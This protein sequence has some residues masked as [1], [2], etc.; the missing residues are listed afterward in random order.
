VDFDKEIVPWI[1]DEFFI[2][3]S[4]YK[5]IP[6][7]V[8]PA[9][10]IYF[11]LKAKDKDAC[12]K[13]MSKIMAALKQPFKET[14]TGDVTIFHSPV[15]TPGNIIPDFGITFAFVN[16]F[17]I[18]TTSKDAAASL[19]VVLQKKESSLALSKPFVESIGTLAK[20]SLFT[21]FY[22][23]VSGGELLS[24]LAKLSGEA[25]KLSEKELDI[26]KIANSFGG[27]FTYN[28]ACLFCRAVVDINKDVLL[29]SVIGMVKDASAT[30]KPAEEKAK[31][32][33]KK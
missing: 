18:M 15:P 24:G 25:N 2:S 28:D 9:P 14:K 27:G 30:G 23:G 22:N 4:N 5:I 29:K 3:V 7:P 1:G 11:G 32:E 26:L 31:S 8:L 17:I 6:L 33:E 12:M 16:D 21:F 19:T 10:G 13:C 20:T